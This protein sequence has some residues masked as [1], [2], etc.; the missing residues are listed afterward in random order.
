MTSHRK[1][2][3][4]PSCPCDIIAPSLSS[5][6]VLQD[7]ITTL[8]NE[9]SFANDFNNIEEL[10]ADIADSQ[11]LIQREIEEICLPDITIG[12]P[13]NP[14]DIVEYERII[15]RQMRELEL[16]TPEP[17]VIQDQITPKDRA[18]LIDWVCKF[19]CMCHLTTSTLYRCIGIIDRVLSLMYVEEDELKITGIACIHLASK[20]DEPRPLILD[21]AVKYSK[22]EFTKAEVIQVE[23]RIMEKIG[24][25]LNFPTTLFFLTHL[26]R[27]TPQNSQTIFHS[28][29]IAELCSAA[30]ECIG[31]KPSAIASTAILVTRIIT[32]QDPWPEDLNEYT[33][34][35]FEDLEVHVR[36]VLEILLQE[37]R[38]ESR[39]LKF[40]YGNEVFR[41]V[42]LFPVPQ[43][44]PEPFY[45]ANEL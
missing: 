1:M 9:L 36:A 37:D 26:M 10:Q 12:D 40:K 13:R 28:R 18:L 39:F 25:D 33:Q 4:E 11:A 17:Q 16:N 19:H 30:E 31:M 42:S 43:V 7:S 8:L 34:Y 24:Y 5:A 22:N 32:G 27:L 35:S 14:Q 20:I 15:Y 41:Q 45:Y 2:I 21:A 38:E 44:L 3:I 23:S 29:Y 6:E